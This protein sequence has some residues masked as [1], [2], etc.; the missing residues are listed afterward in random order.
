MNQLK[1][2]IIG[3][4]LMLIST[5]GFSQ[6][7]I[8][9]QYK[10]RSEF[11]NGYQQALM[12]NDFSNFYVAQRA[13]LGASYTHKK[14]QFKLSLQDVRTW[15]N[16]YNIAVDDNGFLSVYEANLSLF[17]NKKWSVKIGRQPISY[18][19]DRIFGTLDWAMQARRH[20]ALIVKFR[21]KK[22]S[23]DVGAT[24][25]SE[26]PSNSHIIYELNNYKTF[27]YV[28]ANKEWEDFTASV[29]FLNNGMERI[30]FQD[31]VK[32]GAI[33]YSQTFG[34]HLEYK[35]S[36]FDITTYGYYQMGMDKTNRGISAYNANI[37]GTYKPNDKWKLTLGGEVLSGK[38]Q[39]ITTDDINRSFSPL[40]GTNHKFNG[41]MDY[42]YVGNYE[43]NVGLL[44][45]YLK[46]SFKTGKFTFGLANHFFFAAAP[47]MTES[48]PINPET[49]QMDTFLG[50][51]TDITIKYQFIEEIT[52]ELG[53]S[54]LFDTSTMHEIK[55][56][57][58]Q[59]LNN[60]AYLMVTAK[61]FE[62]FKL[63]K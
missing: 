53:Y 39:E 50:Y 3:T 54:Q 60:W 51:E 2:T 41:F 32:K 9:G 14:F 57:G 29:L 34:T 42:F 1:T 47:V 7:D 33:M 49:V 20:D 17:L 16:T 46:T 23:V 56:T 35:R 30:Y 22:W 45:G 28:W 55:G 15:G 5:Y 21:D 40:Y 24:Y 11:L 12:D 44:D 31:S 59:K 38:S 43:K 8:S 48:G 36:K 62:N 63:F 13:R 10:V 18:D 27:Q 37:E 19:N 52:I 58:N 25:N 26:R 4:L 61:P 6:L